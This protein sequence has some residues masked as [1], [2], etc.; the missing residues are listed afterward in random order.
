MEVFQMLQWLFGNVGGITETS[1]TTIN[2]IFTYTAFILI[3]S[4]PLLFSIIGIMTSNYKD[5]FR[6]L[7]VLN[8][9]VLLYACAVIV[10]IT[11]YDVQ[12]GYNLAKSSLNNITCTLIGNNHHL[13]WMFQTGL[14]DY[15]ANHLLYMVL[16]LTTFIFYKPSISG[17]PLGWILTLFLT[18]LVF[19]T[20]S[21]EIA[22]TW[23]LFSVFSNIVIVACHLYHR[24]HGAGANSHNSKNIEIQQLSCSK[25][26]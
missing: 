6:K 2:K 14:I 7:V 18:L 13:A 15:Q 10:Y 9:T 19:E 4:Q 23:C 12:Y 8:A 21:N 26:V 20:E 16:C 22:S 1:C 25:R 17:I 3:W 24:R 11:E 5:I